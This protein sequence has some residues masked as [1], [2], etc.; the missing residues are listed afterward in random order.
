MGNSLLLNET[1]DLQFN[2]LTEQTLMDVA[3]NSSGAALLEQYSDD[4]EGFFVGETRRNW[5][6]KF[7]DVE[8]NIKPDIA[9]AV[10]R[11]AAIDLIKFDMGGYTG[12]GEAEDLININHDN[13]S[14]VIRKLTDFKSI[15]GVT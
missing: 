4:A 10:A 14:R 11:L 2:S 5:V 6:D 13:A 1:P 7:G 3:L 8:S 12:R 9:N 15:Q